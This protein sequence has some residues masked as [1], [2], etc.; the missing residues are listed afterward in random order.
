MAVKLV[1]EFWADV[2]AHEVIIRRCFH[3]LNRKY[4][5]PEGE[6]S[7]WA[8]LLIR[9][10]ELKILSKDRFDPTLGGVDKHEDKKWEQ[11]LYKWIEHFLGEAFHNRGKYYKRFAIRG[12]ID[13]ATSHINYQKPSRE[14]RVLL[15]RPEE[16]SSKYVKGDDYQVS[17][18]PCFATQD[19]FPSFHKQENPL[20]DVECEEILSGINAVLRNE[21]EKEIIKYLHE[22]KARAEVAQMVNRTPSSVSFVL[23]DIKKRCIQKGLLPEAIK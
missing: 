5:D 8:H 16:S 6:E 22:G 18:K 15:F 1:G 4:P 10:N 9:L 19:T 13:T 21:R 3:F 20:E 14:D 23:K 2:Q 12:D 17:K 11:Y 7:S